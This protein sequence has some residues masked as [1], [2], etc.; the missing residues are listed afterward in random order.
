VHHPISYI[1]P[2]CFSIVNA[3]VWR[4]ND[5]TAAAGVRS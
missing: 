1:F 2:K 5:F 3:R 4:E